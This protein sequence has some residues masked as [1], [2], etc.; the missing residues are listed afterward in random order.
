MGAMLKVLEQF[1]YRVTRRIVGMAVRRTTSGEWGFPPVAE[2]LDTTGLW[3][4]KEYIQQRQDNVVSQ[5]T[6]HTIYDI[7]TGAERI[8]GTS[9]FLR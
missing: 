5:V 3:T 8:P 2:A 6:F 9:R 7:C 1:H 4:I